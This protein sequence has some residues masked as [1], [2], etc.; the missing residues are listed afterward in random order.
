MDIETKV[1]SHSGSGIKFHAFVNGQPLCSRGVER[2][3]PE[4]IQKHG[5]DYC[6]AKGSMMCK[7]CDRKFNMLMAEQELEAALE[8]PEYNDN[9]GDDSMG[10]IER[11]PF[12][13]RQISVISHLRSGLRQYQVATRLN[14]TVGTIRRES[15]I[16]VR[17]MKTDTLAGALVKYGEGTAY[18][19][20]AAK[21][22][23]AVVY[24]TDD[25]TETHANHVLCG[26]ADLFDHEHDLRMPK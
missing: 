10:N 12:T 5:L 1:W 20:A 17:K 3:D 11:G 21:L 19:D 8:T 16:I 22:R 6:E 7:N 18:R 9:K 15:Q 4:Y 24:G 13:E 26:I 25:E 2:R 14:V 23:E